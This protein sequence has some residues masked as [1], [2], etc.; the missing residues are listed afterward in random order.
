MGV[1]GVA[2]EV[3]LDSCPETDQ[4][5]KVFL[6]STMVTSGSEPVAVEPL[7]VSV[8]GVLATVTLSEPVAETVTLIGI[9]LVPPAFVL[10][11]VVTVSAEAADVDEAYDDE[12][13]VK[14]ASS[15]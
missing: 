5:G 11:A 8:V 6:V 12:F 1:D 3:K 7:T 10:P 2:V 4:P 9:G 15:E 13:G 14:T